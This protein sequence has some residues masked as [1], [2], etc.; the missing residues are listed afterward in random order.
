MLLNKISIRKHVL[1]KRDAIR[2]NIRIEKNKKIK[3][4]LIGLSEFKAANKILLYAAFRNEVDTADLI[5][6]CISSR[7]ITVLPKVDKKNNEL[8][9]Y[10]IKDI[11]ELS[12][13]YLG[14][15]EPDVSEDRLCLIEDMEIIIVPGV[16]FDEDCGRLGYGKGFYDKLLSKVRSKIIGLAYEEQ[17]VERIEVD[18]HDIK[19]DNII[20]DERIIECKGV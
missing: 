4:K 13:G 8:K 14:I 17:I 9:L 19:M 5:R 15:P 20:T 1:S 3:D 7:K 2:A 11:S 18:A 12:S 16:A 6:H 10:E